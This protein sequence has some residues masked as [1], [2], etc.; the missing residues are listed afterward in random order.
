MEFRRPD[1][2]E[3]DDRRIRAGDSFFSFLSS[4]F[5]SIHI[6]HSTL[7]TPCTGDSVPKWKLLAHRLRRTTS[8]AA[9]SRWHAG[10]LFRRHRPL[11][12]RRL[13]NVGAALLRSGAAGLRPN[14]CA[15]LAGAMVGSSSTMAGALL[16]WP[17]RVPAV[18]AH[19]C[20]LFLALCTE[21]LP[22]GSSGRTEARSSSRSCNRA[23][24]AATSAA[25]PTERSHGLRCPLSLSPCST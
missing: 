23:V 14:H 25:M 24:P 11:V 17:S 2:F 19:C 3:S 16:Q 4:D 1:L 10:R 9:S 12:I 8:G 20:P 7:F 15:G 13:G 5:I 22:H 6:V 18:V 21:P